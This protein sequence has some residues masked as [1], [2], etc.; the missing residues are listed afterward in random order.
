M[1]PNEQA[2]CC[3]GAGSESLPPTVSQNAAFQEENLAKTSD[4]DK[5]I[6]KQ[7]TGQWQG[8]ILKSPITMQAD[9]KDVFER[10]NFST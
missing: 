5:H 6:P 4:V 9:I 7:D 2:I 1:T 3:S 10:R 8:G